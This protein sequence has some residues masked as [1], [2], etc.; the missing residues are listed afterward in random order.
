MARL[1]DAQKR[2]ATAC[3]RDRV[4][5]REIGR[6]IGASFEAVSLYLFGGIDE[7][8][9]P[10]APTVTFTPPLAT[11]S[12][13]TQ[14]ALQ[15]LAAAAVE[16]IAGAG[17]EA[18]PEPAGEAG[19]DASPHGAD[20]EQGSSAGGEAVNDQASPPPQRLYRLRNELGEYLHKSGTG[21]TRS[22]DT[23]WKGDAR[24]MEETFKRKPHLKELDPERVPG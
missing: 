18:T 6:E 11:L 21:M 9:P 20:P 17:A 23:A 16:Q 15:H 24:Q 5:L 10:Q 4:P 1:S 13:A 19:H 3:G 2:R 8:E 7:F 14:D 12:P 22:L